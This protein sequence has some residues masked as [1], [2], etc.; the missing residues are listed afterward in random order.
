MTRAADAVNAINSLA[1]SIQA[2]ATAVTE[3][4]RVMRTR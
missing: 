3:L 4:A 1:R 2:L